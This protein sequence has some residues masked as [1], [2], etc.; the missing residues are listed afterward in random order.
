MRTATAVSI[1]VF[2]AFVLGC[3]GD[4]PPTDTGQQDGLQTVHADGSSNSDGI[5][6]F[7]IDVADQTSMLLTFQPES[8]YQ[9]YLSALYDPAG[10]MVADGEQLA[11][12]DHSMTGAVFLNTEVSLNWPILDDQSLSPGTWT[13]EI[14]V[15]DDQ[16]YFVRNA[17]ITLDGQ[18]KTDDDLTGGVLA[19]DVIYVGP[20]QTDTEA[21]RAMGRALTYWEQIYASIGITLDVTEYNLDGPDTMYPPGLGNAADYTS[22]ADQTGFRA[23][24]VVVV[25]DLDGMDGLYGM[26][27]G[28][29]GPLVATGNSGVGVSVATNAGPDLVFNDGE[30][31]ILGETL[32]HE[33]GHYL[34]ISHPVESSY[35]QWDSIDDTPEC[36]N[37]NDC[38]DAL[39]SNLM[40]P[41]PVCSGNTCIP[42]DQVT[43]QQGRIANRYTGVE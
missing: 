4:T 39:G 26:S 10:N 11:A 21:Q 35:D 12:S 8:P 40:F 32:A 14:G 15:T 2:G 31:G 41:Y 30:I 20:V 16:G 5:A 43:A 27:G 23:I 25:G 28:I 42:Q 3:T 24:N 34:G 1:V 29:P 18:L 19:V 7:D 17:N 38:E 13:A 9:A 6:T 36:G 33:V 22:I 37:D